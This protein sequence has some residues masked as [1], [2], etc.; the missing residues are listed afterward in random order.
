MRMMSFRG[1]LVRAPL[2]LG[3]VWSG[4]VLTRKLGLDLEGDECGKFGVVHRVIVHTIGKR[5]RVL[6][7]FTGPAGAWRAVR[8]LDG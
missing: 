4:D 1:K 2:V 5:V 6:V 7:R 3:E 8:E